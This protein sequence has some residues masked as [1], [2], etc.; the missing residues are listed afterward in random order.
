M[1]RE[2]SG[3]RLAGVGFP[4]IGTLLFWAGGSLCAR[5][6]GRMPDFSGGCSSGK[7]ETDETGAQGAGGAMENGNFP[8]VFGV[9]FSFP[10][11]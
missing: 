8:G 9:G 5:P 7:I 4:A 3:R 10:S 11:E 2:Y 6:G 1:G